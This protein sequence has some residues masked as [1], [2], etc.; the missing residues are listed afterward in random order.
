MRNSRIEKIRRVDKDSLEEEL[1]KEY[2]EE[3]YLYIIL[4]VM[5]EK[6]NCPSCYHIPVEAQITVE[7]NS[8]VSTG[9]GICRRC[10]IIFDIPRLSLDEIENLLDKRWNLYREGKLRISC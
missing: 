2:E 7:N 8:V 1:K 4:R 10:H 6:F 3:K 9:K 5:T